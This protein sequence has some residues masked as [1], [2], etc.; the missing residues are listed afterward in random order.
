MRAA[1]ITQESMNKYAWAIFFPFH[2]AL[3]AG[4]AAY[5][6]KFHWWHGI[7][8]FV[9]WTLFS[10]FGIGAGFHRLLAHKAFKTSTF[11]TRFCSLMG[12]FGIQGSPLFWVSVHRSIHHPFADT[13]KDIHSPV[14]GKLNAY[15][16]WALTVEMYKV[17]AISVR[18]L[19]IDPFQMFLHKRYFFVV[20]GT[21]AA[22]ALLS[23]SIT[24]LSILPAMAITLHQEFCVNLFCHVRGLGGYRNFYTADDSVNRPLLG[25]LWGVGYHNNHHNNPKSYDFG[26]ARWWEIDLTKYI[27][28]LIKCS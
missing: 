19:I 5:W 22:C 25:L 13:P 23:P 1:S 14:H 18:D 6:N 28:R 15:F 10:G 17:N 7:L 21:L 9:F 8:L 2:L 3:I 26:Y 12:C 16:M 11:W 27:V 20:V 24:A 4:L